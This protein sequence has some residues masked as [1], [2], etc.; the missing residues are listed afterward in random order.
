[1]DSTTSL[2]RTQAATM[3]QAVNYL[4]FYD[5]MN[6]NPF[7]VNEAWSFFVS[8]QVRR[9][10]DH[11]SRALGIRIAFFD[12]AGRQVEAGLDLPSCAYCTLLRRK[13]GFEPRCRE[14]DQ[15][16]W[17][18]S[19]RTGELVS[20]RCHGGMTEAIMPLR[21]GERLVGYVM[22]GQF[23]QN[24]ELPEAVRRLARRQ[25]LAEELAEAFARTPDYDP[26]RGQAAI[27]LF[28]ALTEFIASAQLI[29]PREAD[30]LAQL[31]AH[32]EANLHRNVPLAEAA[33]LVCR[34][35]GTLSHLVKRRLGKSFKA[36]Q[37]ELKLERA[38][39]WRREEP[40]LPIKEL[41]RRLGYEDP[42]FFSRLY[43]KYRGRPPSRDG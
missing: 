30:A 7:M 28:V 3:N 34:S 2:A 6:N 9:I 41:A 33:A 20:Y 27:G 14:L 21:V 11:Y 29:R 1:M 23:R 39:R 43:R 32:L 19:R 25:G 22:I 12:P 13:L 31:R 4:D 35:P 26:E 8:P 5:I 10:F 38:A 37:I 16:M 36:W 40:E 15:R 24:S 42:F 18:Q 17:A